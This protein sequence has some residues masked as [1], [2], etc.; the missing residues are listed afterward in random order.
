MQESVSNHSTRTC[1]QFQ[2]R[3]K[4]YSNTYIQIHK[5]KTILIFSRLQSPK[6][7]RSNEQKRKLGKY[8]VVLFMIQKCYFCIHF[9]TNV[10]TYLYITNMQAS[11][12]KKKYVSPKIFWPKTGCFIS[13]AQLHRL[14]FY[15]EKEEQLNSNVEKY[16]YSF[17]YL[18]ICLLI[19]LFILIL[20]FFFCNKK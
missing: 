14:F 17:I 1:I 6:A 10:I 20:F 4:S 13:E 5:F 3:H 19:C 9:S 12:L 16:G 18:F 7:K 2:Y 11:T 15:F 8:F